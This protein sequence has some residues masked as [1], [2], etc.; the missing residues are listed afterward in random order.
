[1]VV[2]LK[3]A[4]VRNF[5]DDPTESG[6]VQIRIYNDENDEQ[7]IKDADLPW[8]ILGLPVTS[9]STAKIGVSPSGLIVGSRVLVTYM[10]YDT[11]EQYP[12]VLCSLGRGDLPTKKG[13]RSE[14]D[15]DSGGSIRVK[16]PDNPVIPKS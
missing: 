10:P 1:M 4:E 8:A 9:A 2:T 15:G 14:T 3:I 6:R 7:N 11:A 13:I 5:E 12:I 16:G